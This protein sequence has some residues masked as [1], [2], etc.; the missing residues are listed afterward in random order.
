M[1]ERYNSSMCLEV[2]RLKYSASYI[3]YHPTHHLLLCVYYVACMAG[4]PELE[5]ASVLLTSYLGHHLWP[6]S[7]L[8]RVA[9]TL[10]MYF[11]LLQMLFFF[12]ALG[13]F[14]SLFLLVLP[15]FLLS[16]LPFLLSLNKCISSMAVVQRGAWCFKIQLK[17]VVCSWRSS[18]ILPLQKQVLWGH[19]TLN[20]PLHVPLGCKYLH[21]HCLLTRLWDLQELSLIH[22]SPVPYTPK[23]LW[24]RKRGQGEKL[25]LLFCWPWSGPLIP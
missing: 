10:H 14:S 13:K 18:P 11:F 5:G 24:E 8:S 22:L 25:R 12:L 1:A 7:T 9:K 2:K 21:P 6:L 17:C 15:P 3:K 19:S 23:G 16:L 20:I 4:V